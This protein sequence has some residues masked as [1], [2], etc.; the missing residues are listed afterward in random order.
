MTLNLPYFHHREEF[1]QEPF[2]GSGFVYKNTPQNLEALT[3]GQFK[4]VQLEDW[5]ICPASP[6]AL[7]G[8][9]SHWFSKIPYVRR[10]K[11]FDNLKYSDLDENSGVLFLTQAVARWYYKRCFSKQD[12]ESLLPKKLPPALYIKGDGGS[13]FRA[14]HGLEQLGYTH[15]MSFYNNLGAYEKFKVLLRGNKQ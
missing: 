2:I 13:L 9:N 3:K 6:Y 12:V 11:D 15:L 8:I 4:T 10:P 14:F 5:I 1:K 7:R